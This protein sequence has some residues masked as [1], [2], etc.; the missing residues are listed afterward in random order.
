MSVTLA[1]MVY[2]EDRTGSF[3]VELFR[4][5]GIHNIAHNRYSSS[6]INLITN[7]ALTFGN[8]KR[9]V[10]LDVEV[11][12]TIYPTITDSYID[13][14]FAKGMAVNTSDEPVTLFPVSYIESINEGE[15]QSPSVTVAPGDT[16]QL[17]FYT[18][19]D[20]RGLQIDKGIIGR[21][22]FYVGTENPGSDEQL[23]KPVLITTMNSWDSNV[24]H[25]RYFV[26]SGIEDVQPIV[27]KLLSQNK[28]EFDTLNS[29]AATLRKAK[30]IFE[31]F[32]ADML[33][34]ADP[35]ASSE[36]VQFP[37]Q[38]LDLKGGDCDDFSVLFAAL[39]ES[40]GIET[41]F[42]D[43]R[44]DEQVRHVNILINTGLLPSEAPLIT[45]NDRKYFIRKDAGG[46]DRVWIPLET[47]LF[48]SFDDAWNRGT[49]IFN[50]AAID[51]Y[52]LAK[53][54]VEIFD[55]F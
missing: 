39:F 12:H 44:S 35:R 2:T 18:I 16:A 14:P 7:L 45:V 34:A 48:S 22:D 8:E 23:Q 50:E 41:A 54:T 13:R 46:I 3:P 42:V 47:T 36:Y 4:Q 49:E 9:F 1:G 43:Y 32:A 51:E 5:E 19:I 31:Y 25:L 21:A 11:L 30:I 40:I 17:L 27:K 15:I 55:I 24:S 53:G 52:G 29:S 38:T 20:K 33:Y 26:Q 6:N 37:A 10:L 28:D